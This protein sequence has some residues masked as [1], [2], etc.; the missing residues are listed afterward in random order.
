MDEFAR[1]ILIILLEFILFKK[2]RLIKNVEEFVFWAGEN[3]ET[4][5]AKQELIDQINNFNISIRAK[6]FFELNRRFL[7]TVNS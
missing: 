7:A 5:N 4:H 1:M 2:S 3:A 6:G